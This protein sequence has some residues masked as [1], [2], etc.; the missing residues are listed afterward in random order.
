MIAPQGRLGKL[1]HRLAPLFRMDAHLAV[2]LA[3][4]ALATWAF[5]ALAE[6]LRDRDL[7]VRWD[8]T[9]LAWVH[10]RT[11]PHGTRIFGAITQLGNAT[12]TL[13]MAAAIAPA[14]RRHRALL[15]GWILAFT[16]GLALERVVKTVVQR[17]RPPTAAAYM[18]ADSFSFPSGHAT[19]SMVAYVMLAYALA[20][21]MEAGPVRRVLLY[22]GAAV[23]IGAVGLSRIY[24]GVHYPSD[25]AAGFTV[26]LAWVAICMAGIR[27][28]E[29]RKRSARSH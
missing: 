20:H 7:F 23:I 11:T 28:A 6:D 10:R 16:G 5:S 1:R 26:G 9:V 18:H 29:R 14:L 25:V 22:L 2:A 4:A 15:V 8:G 19:A 3:V 24:L 12:F 21:L 17:V 27:L 13:M